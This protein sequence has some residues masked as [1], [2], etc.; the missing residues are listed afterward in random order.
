MRAAARPPRPTP[1]LAAP[2]R[3]RLLKLTFLNPSAAAK[4][5]GAEELLAAALRLPG[6]WED[7]PW[8]S[9]VVKAGKKIFVFLGHADDG[10]LF[11]SFKLPH[12]HGAALMLPFANPTAYGLGKSG[13]IT[14]TFA[15]GEKVPEALLLE[16]L[17][18]SYVAVAPKRLVKQLPGN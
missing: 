13:W 2:R 11:A 5:A 15:K 6:A 17:Q 4:E 7:H 9:T 16:W 10:S 14:A 1:L 3:P 8:G 18:E 12:S